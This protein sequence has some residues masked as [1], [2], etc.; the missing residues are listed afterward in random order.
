[1]LGR[2]VVV[3]FVVG[4]LV[5]MGLVLATGHHGV[6]MVESTRVAYSLVHSGTL[7]NA[8]GDGGGPTAHLMPLYPIMLAV[9][10]GLLGVGYAG[11]L[12]LAL[13][14]SAAAALSFAL[15]PVL[16]RATRLGVT[17]GIIAG[18][19]GE[20]APV[21]FWAQT[22]GTW[23][24]PMTG[25]CLVVLA[26]LI[27]DVWR[28]GQ[29]TVGAAVRIGVVG[30]AGVL[31]NAA[32]IPVLVGWCVAGA[33][34]FRRDIRP[35]AVAAAITAAMVLIVWTPWI[36]RNAMVFHALVPTRTN[37]GLE[38]QVSNNDAAVADGERNML[39]PAAFH[40]PAAQSEEAAR[41]R[42]MGEI[43]Y[44]QAKLAQAKQWI[45]THPAAFARLTVE[46]I[47]LFWFPP[48]KRPWQTVAQGA[49]T[50]AGLVGLLLLVLRRDPAL[51]VIAPVLLMYPAIYTIVQIM[52]RY[53]YPLEPFLVLLGAVAVWRLIP[54]SAP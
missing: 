9:P 28:S 22:S 50:A 49:I 46:R 19:V 34:H 53:R 2:A 43:A 35:Y 21:N 30:G 45:R 15:L 23:E 36:V 13:M 6:E 54:R 4:V 24:A 33:W 14:A 20:L 11:H 3:L 32:I 5:R 41:V 52:P 39:I 1:V 47:G 7:A 27:A 16:G 26:I 37:L 17:P 8:Y 48:M 10:L 38:V 29:F 44:N 18:A 31:L 25:L 42:T 51:A 40:H 12:G